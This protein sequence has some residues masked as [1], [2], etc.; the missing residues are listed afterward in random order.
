MIRIT[1]R[2]F[3]E[4]KGLIRSE[5]E[6]EKN[7]QNSLGIPTEPAADEKRHPLAGRKVLN[8]N[9]DFD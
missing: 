2:I 3:I 7:P 1:L 8:V 4:S 6:R 5:W 9:L